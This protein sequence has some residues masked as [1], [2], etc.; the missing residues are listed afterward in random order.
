M[1]HKWIFYSSDDH[2]NDSEEESEHFK[3]T[4]PSPSCIP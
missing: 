4:E 1:T 2:S 3:L